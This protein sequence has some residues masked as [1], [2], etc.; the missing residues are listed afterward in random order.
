[1]T[2]IS[3]YRNFYYKLLKA[4]QTEQ[5]KLNSPRTVVILVLV[6]CNFLF[7]QSNEVIDE[8]LA[9]GNPIFEG[10]YADP[11]VIIFSDE[12]WIYPT[13]SCA[14]EKQTFFDA[15][16]SRD[17][18]HWKK[19]EKILDTT[20]ITWAKQAMWAPSIVNKDNRYFLFF[21][22]NDVQRPG[23]KSYDPNND[24]NHYGGIGIAVSNNPGGPYKDYLGKPLISDFHNDA[25]PIDQFV[26]K[27]VD[28]LYYLFYGGWGH[29][30]LG[31]LNDD[32]KTIEPWEDG[33]LFKEITPEGYVEGP[34]VFLRNGV[35]Y[36][37]WSEGNWTDDSYKVVYAIAD[38]VTGPY[39]KIGA[40]LESNPKIATG[41]GHH[42]VISVPQTDEWI[43]V[44]HR[45]PI[46]NLG[47][48]H[49]VV[50]MDRME[51][52][53]DGTIKPVIMTNKG[54]ARTTILPK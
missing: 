23:R 37:T 49:R 32:F 31:K 50:C 41:A 35:Y 44:Y 46:P 28:G 5:I 45:R 22:A 19:Y 47:R 11:E 17:L 48:D 18:R 14:F 54:V 15:F 33:S 27:D 4:K 3:D 12:F 7:A 26:F 8:P 2:N 43:I 39:T 9:K 29:C 36:F 10:W 40:V 42:S 13:F 30:N 34:F 1:M 51:F 38:K 52:N 21:G 25:Q 53:R 6:S 20:I 16:S 24:I